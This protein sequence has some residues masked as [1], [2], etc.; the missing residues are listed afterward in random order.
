VKTRREKRLAEE[1]LESLSGVRDIHNRLRVEG[2]ILSSL[3]GGGS[4]SS[5]QEKESGGQGSQ[6]INSQ[7]ASTQAATSGT[8]NLG[9]QSDAS[10]G[11]S[12]LGNQTGEQSPTS[13]SRSRK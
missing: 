4:N 10:T 3:F 9:T 7:P 5:N 12:M 8:A 6:S 11:S 13:R 1:A 2:G